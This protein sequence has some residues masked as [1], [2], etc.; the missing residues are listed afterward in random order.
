MSGCFI[1]QKNM[2]EPQT[3]NACGATKLSEYIFCFMKKTDQK[4][5]F[6]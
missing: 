6:E 5:C 3:Q 2:E 4:L 1:H